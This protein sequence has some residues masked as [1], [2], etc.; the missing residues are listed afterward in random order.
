MK[1]R[2]RITLREKAVILDAVKKYAGEDTETE[3]ETRRRTY[4]IRIENGPPF[5]PSGK[6]FKIDARHVC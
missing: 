1:S 5:L 2:K 4:R 6:A 3:V